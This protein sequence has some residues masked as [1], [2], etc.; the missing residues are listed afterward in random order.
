[1][2]RL[3]TKNNDDWYREEELGFNEYSIFAVAVV[4]ALIIVIILAI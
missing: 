1:M 2:R 4:A 3:T